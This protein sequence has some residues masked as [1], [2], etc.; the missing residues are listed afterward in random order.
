MIYN[1]NQI[2]DEFKMDLSQIFKDNMDF[3]SCYNYVCDLCDKI[4]DYEG[5]IVDSDVL[6]SYLALY[7]EIASYLDMLE[8]Y[9]MFKYNIN[10]NDVSAFNLMQRVKGLSQN[11]DEATLFFSNEVLKYDYEEILGM[12]AENEKLKMFN[13]YLRDIFRRN[14]YTLSKDNEEKLL[15]ELKAFGGTYYDY[16]SITSP[17][18]VLGVIKDNSGNEVTLTYESSDQYFEDPD[19]EI[20]LEMYRIFYDYLKS[21]NEKN[22]VC[23]NNHMKRNIQE[24]KRRGY[25]SSLQMH[26]FKDNIEENLFDI[27]LNSTHNH[28]PAL[29]RYYDIKAKILGIDIFQDC[30]VSMA[31]GKTNIRVPFEEGKKL[32]FESLNPLGS[33]YIEKLKDLLSHHILD[34][35]P[36]SAKSEGAMSSNVYLSYPYALINYTDDVYSVNAMTHELG[37]CMND[38]YSHE[39]PFVYA[40][41]SI[42]V[43]ECA[44]IVNQILLRHYMYK[45]AK[46]SEEKIIHLE[47]FLN[48][49]QV[50]VYKQALNLEFEKTTHEMALAG[51]LSSDELNETYYNLYI[52]YRGEEMVSNPGIKY[53]WE[54][55]S[56]LY[57]NFYSY[58]YAVGFAS[59]L[60]I[61]TSLLNDEDGAFKEQYLK[62]LAS[63]SSDYPAAILSKVGV[64]IYDESL[65]EAAFIVFEQKV[66]EL[67]SLVSEQKLSSLG[68]SYVKS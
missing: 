41:A 39:Q 15:E 38:I 43:T 56:Q 7:N 12:F 67:D 53:F 50:L 1:R 47:Q 54:Q 26:L 16:L 24:A 27:L 14:R 17:D 66:G 63:G 13:F 25:D 49:F 30:D 59:A 5:K 31:I 62:Y 21:N 8:N 32:M 48:D 18:D 11:F 35:Y 9:S 52:K 6:F 34:V 10:Q 45:K 2:P 60:A 51:E 23:Y 68:N 3:E 57:S 22:T 61:T 19:R 44:A 29:R 55:N 46:T 58:K 42:M 20:R 65:Y 36:T 28:L 40:N 4:K 33:D 64:D 37:H